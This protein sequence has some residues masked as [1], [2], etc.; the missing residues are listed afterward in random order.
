MN[1]TSSE[2]DF[3]KENEAYRPIPES[4]KRRLG[5]AE[6]FDA[7]LE[8]MRGATTAGAMPD[9][10]HCVIKGIDLAGRDLTGIDFFADPVFQQKTR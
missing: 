1:F 3:V 10:R 4:D 9:M 6:A 2:I 7:E 5:S 8:K